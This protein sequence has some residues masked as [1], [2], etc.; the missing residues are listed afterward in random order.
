LWQLEN[1]GECEQNKN[2]GIWIWKT[3]CLT[4]ISQ[5]KYPVVLLL[6]EIHDLTLVCIL[7]IILYIL[8]FMLLS[9]NLWKRPSLH[10]LS[11]A[12]SKS[13]NA[14]YNFFFFDVSCLGK[15]FTAILNARLND[16]TEEFMILKENQSGFRQSYSTLDNIF[17]TLYKLF[18]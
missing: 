9:N 4:P 15:L 5:L 18:L 1:E 13:I 14:Q 7:N 3:P 17:S 12:F 2:N 8:P 11:K 10:T 6:Y 16:Y